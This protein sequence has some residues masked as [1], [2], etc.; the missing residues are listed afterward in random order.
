MRSGASSIS[1]PLALIGEHASFSQWHHWLGHLAFRIFRHVLS[2][3]RLPLATSKESTICSSCQQAKNY[4]LPFSLS[5]SFCYHPLDLIFTNVCGPIPFLS[6]K[7][8]RYYVSFLDNYVKY[9]WLF[10]ITSKSNVYSIFIKFQSNVK[11]LF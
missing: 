3:F 1:T 6:T 7:G 10:P 4:S 11:C 2:Q 9:W 8:F 5:T